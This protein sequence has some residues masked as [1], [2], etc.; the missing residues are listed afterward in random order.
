MVCV[1]TCLL[2]PLPP[3]PAS[4]THEQGAQEKIDLSRDT[5]NTAGHVHRVTFPVYI[6]T[7]HSSHRLLST[8]K[9]NSRLSTLNPCRYGNEDVPQVS[10]SPVSPPRKG[11]STRGRRV[12]RGR[13]RGEGTCAPLDTHVQKIKN[14]NHWIWIQSTCTTDSLLRVQRGRSLFVAVLRY[15]C[16]CRI[17][18]EARQPYNRYK[19][20]HAHLLLS[21]L[22][23]SA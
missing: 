7:H 3:P 17:R 10:V 20:K 6:S 9:I 21:T 16:S 11:P 5:L 4:G 12:T 13:R 14:K 22:L 1:Y 8:S 18:H 15:V 19:R 2:R 23:I